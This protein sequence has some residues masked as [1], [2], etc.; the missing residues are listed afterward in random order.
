MPKLVKVPG[1]SSSMILAGQVRGGAWGDAQARGGARV[2]VSHD[3]SWPSSWRYVWGDAQARGGARVFH[4]NC[5]SSWRYVWGDVSHQARGVCTPTAPHRNS[6]FCFTPTAPRRNSHFKF[7]R[8]V[9]DFHVNHRTHSSHNPLLHLH[10]HL[11]HDAELPYF[12]SM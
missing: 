8:E 1:S 4:S 9:T 10:V 6:Y 7:F 5:P 11:P 3:S 12:I 2:F